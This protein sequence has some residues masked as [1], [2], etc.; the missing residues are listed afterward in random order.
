M[1]IRSCHLPTPS[2]HSVA[3]SLLT[4]EAPLNSSHQGGI[5]TT[6]NCYMIM[7]QMCLI[8]IR[9]IRCYCNVWLAPCSSGNGLGVSCNR[10]ASTAVWP[11]DLAVRIPTRVI[12]PSSP[13]RARWPFDQDP[14]RELEG[15][16]TAQLPEFRTGTCPP[17]PLYGHH[18]LAFAPT[19]TEIG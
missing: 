16:S 8:H 4:T 15:E 19:K 10:S 9:H 14:G 3:V 2:R 5:L 6:F 7:N 13:M 11:L 1:S 12:K 18:Q 17:R